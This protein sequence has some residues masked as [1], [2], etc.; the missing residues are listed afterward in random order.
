MPAKKQSKPRTSKS[1]LNKKGVVPNW[2]IAVVLLIVV[3][4][5]LFLIFNSFASG[6]RNYVSGR[7]VTCSTGFCYIN[8]GHGNQGGKTCYPRNDAYRYSCYYGST[9]PHL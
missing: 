4:T 7:D 6:Q 1:R 2:V 5:G 8:A 9:K 3:C